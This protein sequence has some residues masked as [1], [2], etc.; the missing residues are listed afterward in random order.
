MECS[1]HRFAW[2]LAEL[3]ASAAGEPDVVEDRVEPGNGDLEAAWFFGLIDDN[4]QAGE[5]P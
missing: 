4:D 2:A 1:P 5:S 3:R